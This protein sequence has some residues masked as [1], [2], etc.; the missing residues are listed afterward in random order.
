MRQTLRPDDIL[1]TSAPFF[2]R[3]LSQ[4]DHTRYV[5]LLQVL[6]DLFRRHDVTFIMCDGTLLGSYVA[7]DMLPWDDDM[8][9]MVKYA[10]INKIKA[11]FSNTSLWREYEILGYHDDV[12]EYDYSLLTDGAYQ[13]GEGE[14]GGYEGD[15]RPGGYDARP[16]GPPERPD[17][18]KLDPPDPRGP[19]P[20]DPPMFHYRPYADYTESFQFPAPNASQQRYHKFKFFYRDAPRAGGRAWRW[21]FIDVK[22]Y[23]EN[24]THVWTLDRRRKVVPRAVFYPLHSRP[25]AGLWLPAPRDTRAF[26][27]Y[28]Y[29]RFRCRSHR[30]SHRH[31][32]RARPRKVRCWRLHPYYPFV[33]RDQSPAGVV[34]SLMMDSRVIHSVV[35]RETF[36]NGQ[37][38]FEL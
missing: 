16:E 35:V 3:A 9:V 17:E 1:W 2:P 5:A 25:L 32:R 24:R 37:R 21:P 27:Q 7:H 28:K 36:H 18:A 14:V 13:K 29:G 31:E 20:H 15:I 26:L 34:E 23:L 33:W 38:Q 10:D 4:A 8:D 6:A 12:N 30:W 22:Y 11:I 19:D